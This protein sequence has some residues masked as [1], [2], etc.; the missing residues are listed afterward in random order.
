MKYKP[1]TA[2]TTVTR[3]IA[4]MESRIGNIYETVS[5]I[6]KRANQVSAEL[7]EEITHRLSEFTTQ[8]DNLEEVFEN[9]EQIELSR[10]YERMPKPSL[11]A[12]QEYLDGNVYFRNPANEEG[13]DSK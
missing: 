6:A 3:D 4:E 2:S 11:I 8:S 5:V 1:T 9:R 7:K 10:Q 12:I 13:Q